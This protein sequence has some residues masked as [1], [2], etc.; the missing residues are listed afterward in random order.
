MGAGASKP[1]DIAAMA[2]Q[3]INYSPPL[4][5][6]N[7]NNTLCFFDIKLGRYGEGTPIGRIVIELKDDVTPRTAKNFKELCLAPA[8]EGYKGSRF[9][10][11]I[12]NFMCQGMQ[13]S[14]L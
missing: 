9:H 13:F 2:K 11:V 8:N 3:P 4:G 5:P 7:P 1:E 12:Q 14:T 6:P 10:R